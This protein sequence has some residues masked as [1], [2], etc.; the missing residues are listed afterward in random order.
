MKDLDFG[1]IS[2]GI[3]MTVLGYA[4]SYSYKLMSGEEFSI[5][6]FIARLIVA[7]FA[8]LLTLLYGNYKGWD[9]EFI[10]ITCGMAGWMGAGL[11]KLIESVIKQ[12]LGGNDEPK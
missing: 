3:L 5:K 11:I 1:K 10:G 12:R 2:L 8:G 4:A 9:P 6:S 7:M